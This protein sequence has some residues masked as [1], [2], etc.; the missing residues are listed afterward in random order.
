LSSTGESDLQSVNCAP[1]GQA[2]LDADSIAFDHD[3]RVSAQPLTIGGDE[4]TMFLISNTNQENRARLLER[5]FLH[6]LV[7]AAGSIQMLIDLLTGGTTR[8]ERAEYTNLLQVSVN[9]LLSE[10]YHEKVLLD[11]TGPSPRSA[12]DILTALAEYYR[13]HHA[14]RKCRI[15]VSEGAVESPKF[16]GDQTLLVRVLDNMLRNAIEV[17]SR[18]RVVTLGYRQIGE[19]IEFWV[20]NPN[21]ISENVRAKIFHPSFTVNERD[22]DVETPQEAKLLSELCGGTVAVSSDPQFGTT[23]SIRYPAAVEAVSPHRLY[24]TKHAS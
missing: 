14:R 20:H 22:R 21:T 13:K 10:I 23:Y 8:R 2:G 12:H 18:G 15:E 19:E 9:R 1:E 6:D 11:I 16:L 7:N 24:R 17:T 4:L 3:I 5:A